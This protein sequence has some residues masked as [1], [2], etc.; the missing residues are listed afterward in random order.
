MLM[1]LHIIPY[2]PVTGGILSQSY[3]ATLLKSVVRLIP[4]P[5]GWLDCSVHFSLLQKH[6]DTTL[7][8][9]SPAQT[10]DPVWLTA[11][12]LWRVMWPPPRSLP[13]PCLSR[14]YSFRS[15]TS[16]PPSLW[17][18]GKQFILGWPARNWFLSIAYW[19]LTWRSASL[20]SSACQS[21]C[22]LLLVRFHVV[23]VV[24]TTMSSDSVC[25]EISRGRMW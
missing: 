7:H 10:K 4:A 9:N 14:C 12:L 2:H 16:S 11:G 21:V 25:N 23:P 6:S 13:D 8:T 24:G 19:P 3:R 22:V 20:S 17:L 1:H 5:H 15:L 18:A